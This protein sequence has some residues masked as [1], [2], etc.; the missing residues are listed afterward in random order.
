MEE[1]I[2]QKIFK[3]TLPKDK[4]RNVKRLMMGPHLI[5]A[6]F[7][8]EQDFCGPAFKTLEDA[9]NPIRT[10]QTLMLPVHSLQYGEL[11]LQFCIQMEVDLTKELEELHLI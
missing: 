1:I 3:V 5:Y 8:L 4:K 11:Q 6:V 7:S 10:P 2:Q 9:E